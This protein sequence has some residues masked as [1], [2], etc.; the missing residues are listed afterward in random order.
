MVTADTRVALH[1][2]T[3]KQERLRVCVISRR[4]TEDLHIYMLILKQSLDSTTVLINNFKY[5][6]F[7]VHVF[8]CLG[9]FYDAAC[10]FVNFSSF[11][12]SV[13]YMVPDN[14]LTHLCPQ[15]TTLTY[16]LHHKSKMAVVSGAVQILKSEEAL[17]RLFLLRKD[18]NQKYQYWE[19]VHRLDK[20]IDKLKP[21]L[22]V[23]SSCSQSFSG[24]K[25]IIVFPHF[26]FKTLCSVCL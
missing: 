26:Y 5:E 13:T 10:S 4:C 2:I 16:D 20:L 11:S 7:H 22:L 21:Q 9:C 14:S 15:M 8:C 17:Y 12:V 25:H 1:K 3:F 24:L 23:K 18:L 6:Y 19:I